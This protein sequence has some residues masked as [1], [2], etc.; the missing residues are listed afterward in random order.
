MIIVPLS[1]VTAPSRGSLFTSLCIKSLA[2]V[3]PPQSHKTITAT[4]AA[5]G[6]SANGAQ[7]KPDLAKEAVR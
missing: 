3:E 2:V 5:T 4:T 6:R 7:Q 1:V